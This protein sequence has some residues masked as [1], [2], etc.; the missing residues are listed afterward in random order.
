M[1]G[2]MPLSYL[3]YSFVCPVYQAIAIVCELSEEDGGRHR[4]KCAGCALK[5]WP[6]PSDPNPNPFLNP[7]L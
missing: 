7:N 1:D 3:G 5:P 4:D 6:L 2:W